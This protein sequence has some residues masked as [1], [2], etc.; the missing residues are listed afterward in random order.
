MTGATRITI[1][2]SGSSG[3]VPRANGDWGE[4][5]PNNPK[6]RRRRCSALI[7][8]AK[9]VKALDLGEAVTRVVID[10]SPDFREQMISA[11]VPRIDGVLMTHD[12]ADQTHG[13]DDLRA[14]ALY[15]KHRMPVWMDEA[16]AATLMT[17]FGYA[18]KAPANSPYPAI[19]DRRELI[20][21]ADAVEIDG[22]GGKIS[23]LPFEQEHGWIKSV[24]YRVG[25]LAYSADINGLP[26]TSRS[27][28]AGVKCWIVDALREEPHPTHFSVS[29]A[30]SEIDGL[31]I[32]EGVLTNLH[33]T[34]DHERLSS[35]LPKH[36][37]AG[38]D[39]M[40]ITSAAG[41][42]YIDV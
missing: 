20:I 13:L 21:G 18:F 1:L 32:D 41:N 39:G 9:N 28:L 40:K 42:V 24:G 5:D 22:P 3:G 38:F 29:E 7:E 16:T 34:L 25:D 26:L 11:N 8:G 12:H 2:G 27:V 31:K 14:F 37:R 6:N 10:T 36:V 19:L 17:R 35:A 30:I 33:I 15:Q 23:I 4:C